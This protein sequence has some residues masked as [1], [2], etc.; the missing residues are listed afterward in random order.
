M[1][2]FLRLL[3]CAYFL[4]QLSSKY[5]ANDYREMVA[6]LERSIE[7]GKERLIEKLK[8][9]LEELKLASKS[10][11]ESMHLVASTHRDNFMMH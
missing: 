4:I 9:E 11:E 1:H 2:T 5:N 10:R 6:E 7:I 3:F 8:D